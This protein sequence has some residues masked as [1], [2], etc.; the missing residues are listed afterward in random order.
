MALCEHACLWRLG[1]L[2]GGDQGAQWQQESV[3]WASGQA[4]VKPE[5]LLRVVL[6]HDLAS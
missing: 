2:V 3:D 4:I 5:R 6:P 1:E